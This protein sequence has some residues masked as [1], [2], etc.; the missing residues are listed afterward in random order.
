LREPGVLTDPAS[1]PVVFAA[2]NFITVLLLVVGFIAF[3][4][5]IVLLLGGIGDVFGRHDLHFWQKLA[6]LAV[7]LT[8]PFVGIGIYLLINGKGLRQRRAAGY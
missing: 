2:G 3:L 5:W 6:W 7:M 1:M 4:L 8:L